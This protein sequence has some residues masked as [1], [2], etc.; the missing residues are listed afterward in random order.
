MKQIR[1]LLVG[2]PGP[3]IVSEVPSLVDPVK[4]ARGGGYEHFRYSGEHRDL[5]GSPVPVFEWCDRTKIA[6]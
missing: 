1:V 3:D 2:G 5:H 4:V 6:E